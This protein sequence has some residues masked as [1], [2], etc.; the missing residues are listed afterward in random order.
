M[1]LSFLNIHSLRPYTL[2]PLSQHN[3]NIAKSHRYTHTHFHHTL[4]QTGLHTQLYQITAPPLL[5]VHI[6]MHTLHHTDAE[7][8]S[9]LVYKRD[10]KYL[11]TTP[12][13]LYH[14]PRNV[15][16]THHTNTRTHIYFCSSSFTHA[17]LQHT[18]RD[19]FS[20]G[21]KR[22]GTGWGASFL[23]SASL[24]PLSLSRTQTHTRKRAVT[25][26]KYSQSRSF[27]HT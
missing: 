22:T 9:P 26:S 7:I 1:S 23:L 18:R 14:R 20:P 8:W 3:I 17:L 11:P 10:T 16:M 12:T 4:S 27:R 25:G 5:C 6:H 19:S 15:Q 2:V 24:A 13:C 21:H